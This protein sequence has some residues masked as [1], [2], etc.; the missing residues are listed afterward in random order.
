MYR[1]T[2][3]GDIC[4][5]SA[6]GRPLDARQLQSFFE[7]SET[8]FS[9]FRFRTTNGKVLVFCVDVETRAESVRE[10]LDELD[11]KLQPE[12]DGRIVIRSKQAQ[13][14]ID[15]SFTPEE[16]SDLGLLLNP[17]TCRPGADGLCLISCPPAWRTSRLSGRFLLAILSLFRKTH[18]RMRTEP[19]VSQLAPP[20]GSPIYHI[21]IQWILY[22]DV[23]S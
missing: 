9:L 13:M 5:R 14:L 6:S 11:S 1:I 16:V 17:A 8:T 12:F 23:R 3:S 21:P 20:M 7:E 2:E 15:D 22:I 19:T 18:F 10:K 4:N